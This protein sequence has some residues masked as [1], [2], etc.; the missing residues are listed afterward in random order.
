MLSDSLDGDMARVIFEDSQRRM[1]DDIL[2]QLWFHF[3]TF[4][5][6][7]VEEAAI[8]RL[9][10]DLAWDGRA[11]TEEVPFASS[12]DDQ[13]LQERAILRL[14]QVGMISDYL[15]DWGTKSYTIY[16]AG[17]DISDLDRA[18]L[19]FVRRT[20]PGRVDERRD[21][22]AKL[23]AASPADRAARLAIMAMRMVYDSV[24]KSRRRALRE[25]RLLCVEAKRGSWRRSSN[26]SRRLRRFGSLIGSLSTGASPGQMRENSGVPPPGCSRRIRTTRVC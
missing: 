20:Q 2:N 16:L 9:V 21:A 13:V 23:P 4:Q 25:M 26:S 1:R 8:R 12:K 19:Q 7:D 15:K 6:Q 18:F 14:H 10:A 17:A 22:I 24:E 11:R 3:N 5:G